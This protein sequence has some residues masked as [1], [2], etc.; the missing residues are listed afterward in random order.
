MVL[1]MW[2]L[3]QRLYLALSWGGFVEVGVGFEYG[4]YAGK[5]RSQLKYI[6]QVIV[7]SIWVEHD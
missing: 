5:R 7:I 3:V 1:G 4:G 2:R 6:F